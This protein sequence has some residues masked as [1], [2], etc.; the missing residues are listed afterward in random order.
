MLDKLRETDLVEEADD[1][2]REIEN[3]A[4]PLVM[5]LSILMFITSASLIPYAIITG[6]IAQ[7]IPISAIGIPYA[8]YLAVVSG[9]GVVSAMAAWY[10]RAWALPV[11]IGVALVHQAVLL[12]DGSWNVVVL[13]IPALVIALGIT[14]KD[15]LTL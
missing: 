10:R 9:V 14:Q 6:F 12:L 1:T 8:L 13:L 15:E 2:I 4:S 5:L 11:Y 3:P 7:G